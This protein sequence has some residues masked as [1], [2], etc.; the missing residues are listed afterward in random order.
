MRTNAGNF[1]AHFMAVSN[2][3]SEQFSALGS[4]ARRAMNETMAQTIRFSYRKMHQ[5]EENF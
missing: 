1:G 3:A 5:D 2:S 4:V